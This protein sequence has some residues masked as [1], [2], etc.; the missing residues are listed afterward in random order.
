MAARAA[1]AHWLVTRSPRFGPVDGRAV[2]LRAREPRARR[3]T[4]ADVP[5]REAASARA[6]RAPCRSSAPPRRLLGARRRRDVDPLMLRG[7]AGVGR[8]SARPARARRLA[9]ARVSVVVA[10]RPP[11]RA[12]SVGRRRRAARARSLLDDRGSRSAAWKRSSSR[13]PCQLGDHHRRDAVADAVRQRAALAHDPVDPDHERDADGDRLGREER[14]R[15]T[16]AAR[17]SASPGR[18]R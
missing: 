13:S 6:I 2:A 11:I 16:P 9:G 7:L 4:A 18:R 17:R 1:R 12:V 14:A 10:L 3:E 5:G 8:R 15:R